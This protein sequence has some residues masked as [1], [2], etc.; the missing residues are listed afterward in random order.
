MVQI[1]KFETGIVPQHDKRVANNVTH[2]ESKGR[3]RIIM[4][5]VFED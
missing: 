1:G 4:D 3:E 2:P 5:K